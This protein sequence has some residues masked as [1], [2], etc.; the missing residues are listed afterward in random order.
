MK[1]KWIILA[2]AISFALISVGFTRWRK[3][4]MVRE[5]AEEVLRFH[6]LANSDSE[7]DQLLK[8]QVKEAV[9]TYMKEEVPDSDSVEATKEWAMAHLEE[10]EQVAVRVIDEKGYDYPVTACVLR[11]EFPEKSYGD[12]TFPAG[13][14]DALRIEIGE[15]EGQNWWC[16]LYPN[17]CFIDA[18][19]AVVP[20]E[21]KQELKAVLEEDTYRMITNPPKWKISWFF[22]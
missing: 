4:S 9:I 13:R 1:K 20:E 5:L 7:E 11:D 15:A 2:I 12:V 18:V 14:Y 16:V 21:G 6:V 17:L 19:R 3:E 22:F 8:L 10:L